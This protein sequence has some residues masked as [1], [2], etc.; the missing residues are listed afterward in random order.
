[1]EVVK[2]IKAFTYKGDL[3]KIRKD[4]GGDLKT[5]LKSALMEMLLKS[6][7]EDQTKIE[8]PKYK[9]M[10]IFIKDKCLHQV[11]DVTHDDRCYILIWNDCSDLAELCS[12]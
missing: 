8:D 12:N 3:L 6:Q 1:M 10:H 5:Y 4:M 7:T 9:M 2:E 11:S